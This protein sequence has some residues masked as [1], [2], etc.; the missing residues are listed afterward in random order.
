MTFPQQAFGTGTDMLDT[1]KPIKIFQAQSG[2]ITLKPSDHIASGGEGA[3]YRK[4]K[5]VFKLYLDP[6]RA[7]ASGMEEKIRLLSAINHPNIV[8]PRSLVMDA[9]GSPIGFSMDF[10][11]G[12]PIVKTFTNTW[13]DANSFGVKESATLAENM[14]LAI[15]EV[16]AMKALMVDANEM[17]YLV[18]GLSPK[19]IDVD[20]WQI[21]RFKATAIMPSIRDYSSSTFTELSDWYAWAI[22]TF[23][24]F[25][26]SHPYKGSH[27]D[28]K[29]GDLES[30]MK[31]NVSVF[32]PKVKLNG[33]VRDL[34]SI[35]PAL[36]SWYESVFQ[37]GTREIPP[38]VL[39]SPA[40]NVPKKLRIIQSK[41]N[42]VRHDL[43]LTAPF[44][45]IHVARN[46]VAYGQVD[47]QWQAYDLTRRRSLIL[48]SHEIGQLFRSQAA[49][50]R[51]GERMA[52]LTIGVNEL[53]G[54]V[55]VSETDPVPA[56]ATFKPL[57]IEAKKISGFKDT[58]Y[59]VTDNVDK[60]LV[61][62]VLVEMGKQPL[63]AAAQAW[64]LS[65]NATR[66]FN[67]VC[68]YDAIGTPFAIIPDDGAVFTLNASVLRDV[69]IVD[70]FARNGTFVIVTGIDKKTG[71]LNRYTLVA[72][73]AKLVIKDKVATDTADINT[74]VTPRGIAVSLFEDDC[75]DICST[76]AYASKQIPGAGL[77]TEIRLFQMGDMVCYAEGKR[78][79]HL[80]IS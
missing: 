78:V 53:C 31:A 1:G 35:P 50:V 56:F 18:D 67:G 3:V 77:S 17:N 60:G 72:E 23:Q 20:S 28:F 75:I 25:V 22:V 52:L 62:I 21:G 57:M 74:V 34:A 65:I 26:G 47:G 63:I 80:S 59:V 5:T 40:V 4:D 6:A 19:L 49:L 9:K 11:E 46:A 36:R 64:P 7:I 55:V 39:T 38:S 16:H 33:A 24:V 29:R 14:R 66:F 10:C 8:S 32:D 42:S 68:F 41:A 70:A 2:A 76:K 48:S 15:G 37:Y 43:L 79:F 71:V 45:I 27:P 69:S 61:E 58:A 44:E 12:I 13:R 51:F 54:R 30:R 73:G